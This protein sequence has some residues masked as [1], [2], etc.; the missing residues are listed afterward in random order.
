MATRLALRRRIRRGTR[1]LQEAR[2]TDDEV[3]DAINYA[4]NDA[5]PSW[6]AIKQDTTNTVAADTFI[7]SLPTDCYWVAQ[8]WLQQDSDEPYTMITRWRQVQST[9]SAGVVTYYLYLDAAD[10]YETGKTIKVIYEAVPAEL[11]N[12]T[13][14]TIVPD[15]FIIAK[16]KS[17]LYEMLMNEGPQ[18]DVEHVKVLMQWNQQLAEDIRAKR[19]K[20][21][22]ISHIH[23][24]SVG[25]ATLDILAIPGIVGKYRSTG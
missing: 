14:N 2:W 24:S 16:A 11:A 18:Q 10:T 17:N 1:D 8:V 7:Y 22:M 4:I 3:N 13:D 20:T 6:Y 12:D 19:G 25:G 9:S 15:D 23:S 5:W 21:H